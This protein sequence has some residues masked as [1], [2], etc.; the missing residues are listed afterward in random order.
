MKKSKREWVR[1][2]EDD[3]PISSRFHN[4]QIIRIPNHKIQNEFLMFLFSNFQVQFFFINKF[5][6]IFIKPIPFILYLF[7]AENNDQKQRF[8]ST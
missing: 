5:L 8:K 2:W 7:K 6:N 1:G 3:K 4:S